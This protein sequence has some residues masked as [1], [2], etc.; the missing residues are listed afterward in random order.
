MKKELLGKIVEEDKFICKVL[1]R[2]IGVDL[3]VKDL[4]IDSDKNI[5]ININKTQKIRKLEKKKRRL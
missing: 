3:G 4:A 2:G 5:Y 1:N